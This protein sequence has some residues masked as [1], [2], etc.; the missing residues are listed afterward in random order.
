MEQGERINIYPETGELETLQNTERTSKVLFSLTKTSL[1]SGREG[2]LSA[3][4][5]G[6]FPQSVE[7]ID[8]WRAIEQHE[9]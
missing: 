6:E 8:K 2:F 3:G 4:S 9:N 5:G 1:N 7:T